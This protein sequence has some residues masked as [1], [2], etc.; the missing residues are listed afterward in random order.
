MQREKIN[1]WENLERNVGHKK[2]LGRHRC[3]LNCD[4]K[5]HL[6]VTGL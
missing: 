3:G 2:S 4:I 5:M 1:A 6:K